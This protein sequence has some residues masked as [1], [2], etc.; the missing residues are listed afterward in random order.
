MHAKL[1]SQPRFPGVILSG[2]LLTFVA[3]LLP[4]TADYVLFHPDERHYVD[5]GIAMLENG[6]WLTPRT[7]EGELRLKK[8][9]LPYWCT[10]AGFSSVGVSPLGARLGF[11]TAGVGI[12]ALAWWG[13]GLAFGSRRAA[14][15]AAVVAMTQPALVISA[16]R[17][18]P[19]VLL[20]LGVMLSLCGFLAIE[21]SGRATWTGLLAALGGGAVAILSKGLP[22]AAFLGFAIL[23]TAW[24]R[25]ALLSGDWKRWSGALVL[26]VAV[27]GSWFT[28][29][30]GLHADELVEQFTHDQVGRNRFA[31]HAW[32]AVTQ[33]PMCIGLLC[34]M[35]APWLLAVTPE[36]RSRQWRE[37]F[38]RHPGVALMASWAI[39]YCVLAAMINH[40]TPRYLLPVA[41]P[42]SILVGG[43]LADVDADRLRQR[44]WRVLPAGGALTAATALIIGLQLAPRPGWLLVAVALGLLMNLAIS[45]RVQRWPAVAQGIVIAA[46]LQISLLGTGVGLSWHRD[47]GIGALVDRRLD[48]LNHSALIKRI[49]FDGE[50]AHASQIR[51]TVGNRVAVEPA[52]ADPPVQPGDLL[53]LDG[54]VAQRL[55]LSQCQVTRVPCGYRNM[56][57]DSFL[58]S[59]CTGRLSDFLKSSRRSYV[60]A[61][62]RHAPEI[63]TVARPPESFRQ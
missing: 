16:P 32:Q 40:V 6:D 54:E 30:A 13:A 59:L 49:V 27:S 52:P 17:S 29:M 41:A 19:D 63:R 34:A 55:D 61:H 58:W 44:L 36:F 22:G 5:A 10:L 15:F 24:R 2:L 1:I 38:R 9:I 26:F 28:V 25:P 4:L 46:S 47:G 20:A 31:R 51:V 45:S 35:A 37:R 57:A 42:L 18:V 60:L 8:P 12:V 39:V 7:A 50:I 53:V 21:R 43:L 56:R 14:C 33:L 3:G 11:L 48:E 23:F 62:P